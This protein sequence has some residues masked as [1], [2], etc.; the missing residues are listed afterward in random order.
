[1][2]VLTAVSIVMGY[3]LDSWGLILSKSKKCFSVPQ[4]PDELWGPPSL[5]SNFTFLYLLHSGIRSMTILIIK[6]GRYAVYVWWLLYSDSEEWWSCA[7]LSCTYISDIRSN[8]KDVSVDFPH[9]SNWTGLITEME[10]VPC[11]HQGISCD[12]CLMYPITGQ[13]FKCKAC[14]DFNYCENCFYTKKIHRHNFNRI[15]EPGE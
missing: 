4:H 12:G 2:R 9:Q 3:R 15:V 1:L 11:C 7:L 14:D 5:L 10:V 8:G 13:R 6:S